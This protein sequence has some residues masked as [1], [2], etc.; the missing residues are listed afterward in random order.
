MA[1][2]GSFGAA[3]RE[4]DQAAEKD[5]FDFFGETFTIHGTVPPILMMQLGAAMAGKI[6]RY[7]GTA[8]SWLILSSALTVPERET[9]DE[10]VDADESQFRQFVALAARKRCDNDTLINLVWS[11]I[12]AQAGKADEQPP[13]SPPGS[14]T[15]STSSNSSA[16][17]SPASPDLRPVDEV[18]GG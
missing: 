4:L 1:S 3:V 6:G 10:S 12:G 14:P 9:D 16:S 17:A 5:T 18:L 13:T 2:I 8:A 11:I 15:D 7:E